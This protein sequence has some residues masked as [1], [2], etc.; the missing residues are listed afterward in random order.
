MVI[1][2]FYAEKGKFYLISRGYQ[3]HLDFHQNGWLLE[4]SVDSDIN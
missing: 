2:D 1:Y 4:G 3:F